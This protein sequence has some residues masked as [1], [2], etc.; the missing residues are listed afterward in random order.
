VPTPAGAGLGALSKMA[1]SN[2]VLR[3]DPHAIDLCWDALNLENTRWW[4]GWERRWG[5]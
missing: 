5:S 4:R 2:D 3:R 1:P